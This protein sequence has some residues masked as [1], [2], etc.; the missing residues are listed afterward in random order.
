[1]PDPHVILAPIVEPVLPPPVLHAAPPVALLPL[2]VTAAVLL[3]CA[4]AVVWWWR[5]GASRR[6]LHRIVRCRD[7]QQG[8]QQLAHWQQRHWPAAPPAWQQ[9]LDRLRFG[10]ADVAAAEC[11][12]RLCAEAAQAGRAR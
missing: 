10:P 5:R 11:L 6:S 12:Q 7:P 4:A 8:A 9:A 3:I 1:M 2:G